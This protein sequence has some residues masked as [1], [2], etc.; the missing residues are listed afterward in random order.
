MDTESRFGQLTA[1]IQVCDGMAEP[2]SSPGTG[3]ERMKVFHE[4]FGS[5]LH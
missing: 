5:L 4:V 3:F 1:D 2:F